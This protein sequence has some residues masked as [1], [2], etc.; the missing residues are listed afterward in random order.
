[1]LGGSYVWKKR[2]ETLVNPQ[3]VIFH[4]SQDDAY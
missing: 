4:F 3:S 2:T 1:M